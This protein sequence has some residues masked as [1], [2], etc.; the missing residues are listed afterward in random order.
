MPVDELELHPFLDSGESITGHRMIVGTFPVYSITLPETNH[1]QALVK[2]RGDMP[3]FYGSRSNNWWDWYKEYIDSGVETRMA[4]SLLS[5]LK[6]N[7]IAISDV[8]S[9]CKRI[10]ESFMDNRLRDITWNTNLSKRI[11]RGIERILCTG[12]SDQGAM[13]WL[14]KRILMPNGFSFEYDRSKELHNQILQEIPGSNRN[15]NLIANVLVKN[16]K[17]VEII[18]LPSPG[19]PERRVNDFGR[20][21]HLTTEYLRK[22][23]SV[24]FNWFMH[25]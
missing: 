14:R 13:G 8:I 23:L 9:S 4:E 15:I 10:D 22:Y 5:S 6:R 21:E 1:K 16:G 2:S 19:S 24:S 17:S 3:F 18:A 11:E 7:G 25:M 12:K 20:V